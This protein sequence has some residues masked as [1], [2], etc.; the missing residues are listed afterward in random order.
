[1]H[2]FDSGN[3]RFPLKDGRKVMKPIAFQQYEKQ[4]GCLANEYAKYCTEDR[5]FCIKGELTLGE[6][7]ADIAG[8]KVAYAA[9]KFVSQLLGRDPP[10]PGLQNYT[11]DQLFF[12]AHARFYCERGY[13]EK[14][15]GDVHSPQEAR[16]EIA[17]RHVSPFAQAFQCKA[18]SKYFPLKKCDIWGDYAMPPKAEHKKW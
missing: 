2:G 14:V 9:Y 7:I 3:I 6:N 5:K 18:A 4:H 17:Y 8:L 10:I 12:I 16:V 1:M 15:Y 13:S 11:N